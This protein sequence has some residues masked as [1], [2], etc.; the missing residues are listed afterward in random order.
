[1]KSKRDIPVPYEEHTPLNSVTV[2]LPATPPEPMLEHATRCRA[3]E[4]YVQRGM[5]HGHDVDDW[6]KAEAELVH[7]HSTSD[8][9]D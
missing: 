5:A 2:M 8:S 1:M 6:L 9:N 3:Y 4:L 7:G